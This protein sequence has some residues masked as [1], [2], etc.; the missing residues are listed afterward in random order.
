MSGLH[1]FKLS[2]FY[3]ILASLATAQAMRHESSHSFWVQF[4][5]Q[6][7]R[8]TT[9][10]PSLSLQLPKP[11]LK[12]FSDLNPAKAWCKWMQLF[13][14][15]VIN[16][17]WT[18]EAA[19]AIFRWMAPVSDKNHFFK[20]FGPPYLICRNINLPQLPVQQQKKASKWCPASFLGFLLDGE[21]TSCRLHGPAALT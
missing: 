20:T 21:E 13:K 8:K 11:V 5:E 14:Q 1:T 3:W 7:T 10:L 15:A 12:M 16:T 9:S 2:S 6:T 19:M 17:W 4:A 18:R